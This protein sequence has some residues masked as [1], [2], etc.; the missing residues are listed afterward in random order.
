MP[1]GGDAPIFHCD[2]GE[3]G[4]IAGAI[5]D[6]TVAKNEVEISGAKGEGAADEQNQSANHHA[7]SLPSG[8][9]A[10]DT[11]FPLMPSR[12]SLSKCSNASS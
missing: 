4:R 1:D 6:A 11:G 10:G 5:N 3:A 7:A 9:V 8:G 2:I 12:I